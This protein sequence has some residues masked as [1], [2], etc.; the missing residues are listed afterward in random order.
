[1]PSVTIPSTH[2]QILKTIDWYISNKVPFEYHVQNE[3][4]T[5]IS[6]MGSYS[7]WNR[8]YTIP[9]INFIKEVKQHIKG[10]NL[11]DPYRDYFKGENRDSVRYFQYHPQLA[12]GQFIT[13]CEN[14]DASAAYWETANKFGLFEGRPDIYERG[15]SWE[16]ALRK[17][18]GDPDIAEKKLLEK[19]KAGKSDVIR[20]QVRL[21][22]I[23]SLAKKKRVYGFDGR[24]Q[25]LL[26]IERSITTEFLWDIIAE[27]IGNLLSKIAR[28]CGEDFVFYWVDGIYIKAGKKKAAERL[29]KQAGYNC[30]SYKIPWIKTTD[31][32]IIIKC[33]E[34]AREEIRGGQKVI[35]D[36]FTFPFR[37]EEISKQFDGFN[38]DL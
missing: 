28:Q 22:A 35:V 33:P 24:K 18:K 16:K 9:E 31:R 4:L 19:I 6:D 37:T 3:T 30:K 2:E 1:M 8:E 34:K 10:N 27:H 20:K 25:K 15:L 17:M 23:G 12:P 13:D 21:A 7:T 5:I 14:I 26:R 32:H 29:F 38:K 36:E 11:Q